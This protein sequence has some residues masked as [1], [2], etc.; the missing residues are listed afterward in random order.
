MLAFP[1]H[2]M[3]CPAIPAAYTLLKVD[4]D[5]A[6]LSSVLKPLEPYI[7]EVSSEKDADQ[8]G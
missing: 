4:K 6:C 8:S 5:S 2:K 3:S 1:S 7:T